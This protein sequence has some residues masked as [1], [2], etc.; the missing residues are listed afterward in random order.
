M[1][2]GWKTFYRQ[3]NSVTIDLSEEG[4]L[5]DHYKRLQDGYS[6]EAEQVI[7]FLNL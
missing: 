4:D 7:C 6:H 3:N 1:F 2:A 5:D